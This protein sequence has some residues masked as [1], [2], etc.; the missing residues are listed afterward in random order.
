MV[1]VSDYLIRRYHPLLENH[2]YWHSTLYWVNWLSCR[3]LWYSSSL[4]YAYV[5][6][7]QCTTH[8]FLP[9]FTEPFMSSFCQVSTEIGLGLTGF[10]V[11]F[12]LLGI[13]MLF[14]KGFL[15]MGNVRMIRPLDWF[16]LLLISTAVCHVVRFSS[17]L[18]SYWPLGWSQL[19]SSSPSL[20]I[21][22][23]W[24]SPCKTRAVSVPFIF[25][26][27]KWASN[28]AG[29]NIFRVWLF[30]GSHWM[31]CLRNAGGVVW[32]HHALQVGSFFPVVLAWSTS[33]WQ[34][35]LC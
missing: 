35:F 8:P 32:L 7:L 2:G 24:S 23:Y 22:R 17:F 18:A 13:I 16:W 4:C 20:R 21:T 28:Y 10:G 33:T 34:L 9:T 6:N 11:L 27:D 31:A 29:F 14:D 1:S 15:A 19:C 25:L 30:P 3:R 5:A 12:T 26:A